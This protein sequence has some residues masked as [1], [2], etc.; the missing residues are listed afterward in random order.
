VFLFSPYLGKIHIPKKV[1][2]N[3]NLELLVYLSLDLYYFPYLP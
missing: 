1:D 3:E 2:F